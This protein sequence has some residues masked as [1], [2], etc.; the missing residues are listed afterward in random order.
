MPSRISK[1]S[2]LVGKPPVVRKDPSHLDW[3][4]KKPSEEE[5][6]DKYDCFTESEWA[7]H[8]QAAKEETALQSKKKNDP[9][10]MVDEAK[11]LACDSCQLFYQLWA[12]QRGLCKPIDGAITP[13]DK[14]G[15]DSRG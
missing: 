1:K 9:A 13:V 8:Y 10:F 4:Y 5:L 15:V 6:S 11:R 12:R 14:L 3:H 7:A 2:V